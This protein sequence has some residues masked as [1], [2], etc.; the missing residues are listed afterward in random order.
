MNIL[1]IV[2]SSPFFLV[3]IPF[4]FVGGVMFAAADRFNWGWLG[5]FGVVVALV[6]GVFVFAAKLIGGVDD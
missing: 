1:R 6:G 5:F 3:G 2:L 4:V